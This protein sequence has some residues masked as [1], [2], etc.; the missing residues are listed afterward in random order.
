VL[1]AP[2]DLFLDACGATSPLE[3]KIEDTRDQ[4]SKRWVLPQPFALVGRE[5]RA[6]IALNDEEVSRR[7][8]YLQVHDGRVVVFD[9]F[10]RTGIRFDNQPHANDLLCPEQPLGI[11]PFT[12]RLLHGVAE[13][14]DPEVKP[15]LPR[16]WFQLRQGRHHHPPWEMKRE[17]ALVGRAPECKVSLR[18]ASVSRVHCSL[19]R[20]RSGVW[21]VD[22]LGRGG[23]LLNGTPVRFGH[24]EEGDELRIGVFCLRCRYGSPGDGTG[25]NALARVP[26]GQGQPLLLPTGVPSL[27]PALLSPAVPEEGPLTETALLPLVNQLT[28]MQMHMF[29]QFHQAL[30]LVLQTF[31]VWQGN[32]LELVREELQQL[33][34]M[35]RELQALQLPL[36]Q[37]PP[38]NRLLP[39]PS[40]EDTRQTSGTQPPTPVRREA[41]SP[42]TSEPPGLALPSHSHGSTLGEQPGP[43]AGGQIPGQASDNRRNEDVHAWLSERVAT[44][45]RERQSAWQRILGLLGGKKNHD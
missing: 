25:A 10:S 32:Q 29:D 34:E 40:P 6:D 23:V 37:I 18:D 7:H 35:T 5:S 26:S 11:G 16:V 14:R 2:L 42:N 31:G 8:A 1:K 30:A 3:L 39:T 36:S 28:H 24:L 22:L 20:T 43:A 38:G 13:V 4:T 19:V 33:R 45:E 27:S 21:A 41:P 15:E 17:I 9:L 44:L 12:L